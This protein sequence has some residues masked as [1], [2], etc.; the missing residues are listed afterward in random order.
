M[1]LVRWRWIETM[2]TLSLFRTS[3]PKFRISTSMQ[4]TAS[5]VDAGHLVFP[6]FYVGHFPISL[7]ISQSARAGPSVADFGS[8]HL[9]IG[10]IFAPNSLVSHLSHHR[11]ETVKVSELNRGSDG[12]LGAGLGGDTKN[13]FRV[14]NFGYHLLRNT[15]QR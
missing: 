1:G 8:V 11:L 7:I 2:S 15:S 9:G 10:I 3:C 5:P 6:H 13:G 14:R 12:Y 4:P